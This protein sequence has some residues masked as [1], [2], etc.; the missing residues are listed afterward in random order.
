MLETALIMKRNSVIP[1]KLQQRRK[2]YYMIKQ[3]N[4]TNFLTKDALL[5]L[6]LFV[7][8]KMTEEAMLCRA[9]RPANKNKALGDISY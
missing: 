7:F 5:Y 4:Y 1:Q 2:G 6:F 9:E 8:F 3:Q